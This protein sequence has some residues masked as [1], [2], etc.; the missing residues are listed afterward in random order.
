MM[1]IK[2]IFPAVPQV[3]QLS[4]PDRILPA[5]LKKGRTLVA[6]HTGYQNIEMFETKASCLEP[7][8]DI[9]KA[10]RFDH[11]YEHT[12]DKFP[13]YLKDFHGGTLVHSS[14]PKDLSYFI[15]EVK[16]TDYVIIGGGYNKCHYE[17]FS[18]LLQQVL[19]GISENKSASI[20]FPTFCIYDV[21]NIGTEGED[22]WDSFIIKP[23]SFFDEYISLFMTRMNQKN[24]ELSVAKHPEQIGWRILRQNGSK[25]ETED[26]T[27]GSAFVTLNIIQD[28]GALN[29]LLE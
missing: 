6:V 22:H 4:A 14:L 5:S 2:K 16:G 29:K 23:D 19:M 1:R 21:R 26:S 27:K 9:M 24:E 8:I 10:V 3:R 17:A 28:M 15:P 18:H 13:S 7:A 20:F 12:H 11:I 25:M